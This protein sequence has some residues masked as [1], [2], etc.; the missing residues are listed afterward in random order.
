LAN[1]KISALTADTAPTSDDIT[2][3]VDTGTGA[4]KKATFGNIITKAHGLGNELVKVTAGVMGSATAGTDYSAG[5]AALGTGIVKSTT[6]TGV[7]SIAAAGTEYVAGGTGGANQ[8][9]YFT[10]SGA[11]TSSANLAYDAADLT[12]KLPAANNFLIDGRTTPHTD[13]DGLLKINLTTATSNNRTLDLDSIYTSTVGQ[14]GGAYSVLNT[15]T[16]NAV[17][18]ATDQVVYGFYNGVTKAG[19]DTSV[20]I[21]TIYGIYATAANTGSTDAGTK[22][23]YA[24]WFAATGDGAGTSTAYGIYAQAT[25][26]DTNYAAYF[27]GGNVRVASGTL[28]INAT[29]SLN[30]GTSTAATGQITFYNSTNGNTTTIQPGAAAASVT[31]TWPTNVGAA[32]TVLTDAAGDGVLS[33]AAAAGGS[34]DDAYNG[35]ATITADAGAVIINATTVGVD[36][37]STGTTTNALEVGSDTLTTGGLGYFYS[38][39]ADATARSLVKIVNDNSASSGATLLDLKQDSNLYGIFLDW[40]GTS[41]IGMYIDAATTTGQSFVAGQTALTSGKGVWITTS[42]AALSSGENFTSEY[43]LTTNGFAAKTGNMNSMSSTRTNTKTSAT[44]AD[45]FDLLN[46]TRTDITTG[47]GGATNANGSILKLTS[48]CTESAGT[49]NAKYPALEIVHQTWS[50]DT[51]TYAIDITSNNSGTAGAGAI[52]VSSMSTAEPIL[53]LPVDTGGVGAAYGRLCVNVQG[54][55]LKY[56]LLSEAA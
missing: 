2:V 29:G 25:G 23:T 22:N 26:A 35:G 4:N 40:N 30:L 38:N 19:A 10:G 16:H 56:I 39:S 15:F 52:N 51:L 9:A 27:N 48:V 12:L 6:G 31:Y 18:T 21:Y 43:T 49:L 47:A 1:L 8:V 32:G 46:L 17:V 24:G 45:D 28:T 3:T 50:D 55:G 34:L 13:V 33:W 54:V 14:A 11:I 41:N 5:T 53:N 7:L 37:N 20:D 36:I 42:S 44:L